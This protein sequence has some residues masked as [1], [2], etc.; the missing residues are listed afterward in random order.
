[1]YLKLIFLIIS[2]FVISL[3]TSAQNIPKK[4]SPR[5]ETLG[6]DDGLSQSSVY[7]IYQD[8][9]GY[10]WFGTADGL[11]R[12]DG[13]FIKVYKAPVTANTPANSNYICGN[14]LEDKSGNIWYSTETGL[15]VINRLTDEV[16]KK[17]SFTAS[18]GFSAHYPLQLILNDTIWFIHKNEGV[19]SYSIKSEVIQKF[20]F[21]ENSNAV[22]SERFPIT[23]NRPYI[24]HNITGKKGIYEFNC[25]E[26][27][28][29]LILADSAYVI[30]YLKNSNNQTF[31]YNGNSIV[32]NPKNTQTKQI[33]YNVPYNKGAP[34][35]KDFVQD[36]YRRIWMTTMGSGLYMYDLNTNKFNRFE[37]INGNSN[38]LSINFTNCLYIDKNENLWIGTDGGGVCKINLK[39]SKFKLFPHNEIEYPLQ[40]DYFTKCFY[41]DEQKRIWFGTLNNGIC[42]YN[43]FNHFLKN[44]HTINGKLITGVGDIFRDAEK[45]IWI[46][47]S[48]GFAIYSENNNKFTEIAL[49]TWLPLV[50]NN[51]FVYRILQRRSGDLLAAT[52]Q[53]LALIKKNKVGVYTASVML[54]GKDSLPSLITDL[55]E[56]ENGDILLA[57]PS[58]GVYLIDSN[59]NKINIKK[60]FLGGIDL[61]CIYLNNKKPNHIWVGSG[62]GL[63]DLNI[64]DGTHVLYNMKSG[65]GNEYI[66]GIV[67]DE[68]GNLWLSTNGGISCFNTNTK[69]FKNYTVKDGLQSNE[70]NTGAY[71]KGASGN[72]YFGGIKGFNWFNP[73]HAET[74]ITKP[75]VD[76]SLIKINDE[77]FIKNA[78]WYNNKVITQPYFKNDFRFTFSALDFS[79]PKANI[80]S[81][82][83]KNWDSKPIITTNKE[84]TYNNLLPGKYILVVKCR[85][86]DDVWS[87]EESITIIIKSPFWRTWWFNTLV[88]MA[89]ILVVIVITK[90]YIKQKL[91]AQIA[92]LKRQKALDE[93]R[94]RISR[95]MHDDIGAGLTQITLMSESA[96]R[97]NIATSEL[98]D[99]AETSRKLVNNMSEIVWSLN[100]ENKSLEQLIAYLREQLHKLLEHSGKQYFIQLPDVDND[101]ILQNNQSRNILLITKEII[102]NAIKYSDAKC[103][104]VVSS[105]INNELIFEIIDDGIGFDTT[106]I[107]TGNGLKSI[108]AR[109]NEMNATIEIKSIINCGT[110]ITY[111]IPL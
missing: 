46:G 33:L 54:N 72:I 75:L 1:M 84:I 13:E 58:F 34:I 106:K 3:N 37:H 17:K 23:S 78:N 83:L 53:K 98:A 100:P 94:Q 103:I 111:K 105:Y 51:I 15:F 55:K 5:F 91:Q 68:K 36:N 65:I 19:I 108:K 93:E 56:L 70:F 57:C 42:V 52:S 14:V 80:I 4:I 101:I 89:I 6:V 31:F 110:I 39:P 12:Y 86:A 45:K 35:F 44:I 59:L 28:Y 66:Y 69:I 81:Y 104:K 99:I 18:N 21:P 47:H 87:D 61:R 9:K 30:F 22:V 10:M 71:Y 41:E 2:G 95:E 48:N 49:K 85:N 38:S 109:I 40:K 107:N 67:E 63:F 102:N 20:P 76:V 79:N 62:A 50:S 8:S 92:E 60:R 77:I 43:P 11:N 29:K 24:W 27:K 32:I 64:L 88:G 26:K 97:K 82:Q 25:I 16:V 90:F 7:S 74:S 96:K 73:Q